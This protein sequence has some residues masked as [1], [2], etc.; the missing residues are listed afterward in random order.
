[1]CVRRADYGQRGGGGGGG[2]ITH[3]VVYHSCY[4]GVCL[5]IYI[6]VYI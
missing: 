4:Y 2:G 3:F 1:M 6:Y 5:Y